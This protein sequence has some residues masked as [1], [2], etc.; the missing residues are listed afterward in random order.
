MSHDLYASWVTAELAS[1]LKTDPEILFRDLSVSPN[2]ITCFAN[3]ES[4]RKWPIPDGRISISVNSVEIEVALELKRTNEG[5]H[6]VLTATG[7]AQAYLKKG[8]DIS[9]IA[10]PDEYDSYKEP[11]LYLAELLDSIDIY[12]HIIV[13]TYA[14][15]DELNASPFQGKLT[16]HRTI[17]F[18]PTNVSPQRVREIG[19]QKASKQWVHLREGSSDADSF[20]RYLQTAKNISAIDGYEECFDINRELMSACNLISPSISAEK[21]LSNSPGDALQD[22]IWRKFWFDY[23]V[24]KEMQIIW[25]ASP[26]GIKETG[27]SYSKLKRDAQTFKKFF[28]GRSDSVKDK[29]VSELN[30]SP[31]TAAV[32]ASANGEGRK[33]IKKLID[34]GELDTA[35]LSP[36]EVAWLVFAINIHGRAHSF[37]EDIDSGLSHIGMLDDDG[38]A[39]DL[40]YKF[41]D[42]SERSGDCYSGKALQMYG[43]A[44]LKEGQLASFLHYFHRISD[45]VFAQD[46]LL[47]C[48]STI[49]GGKIKFNTAE[50]LQH[51]HDVM[52][53]ELC[54]INT[55]TERGGNS[56]KP[57]QAEF[58]ILN[59]L[60]VIQPQ[61][62]R[63][64]LAIGLIINWP[65]LAEYLEA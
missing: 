22:K 2:T 23:V 53:E 34:S 25:N 35:N 56:R 6:G 1:L 38:R 20:F 52:A 48:F 40:G 3:R 5:L 44:I 8:Y 7:Q 42:M 61:Q 30:S 4:G 37:R 62:F 14:A 58:A 51:I 32:L 18:D 28:G 36:E 13:L 17:S 65:K 26:G 41:V 9:V 31:S 63:F 11:G 54:V 19:S 60:S 33:K 43:S 57:F 55:A 24:T 12:S 59:K 29:I 16:L 15:P 50:Y 10:V 39:S 64:R 46:P 49:P 45:G 27:T 47:F 21:Y